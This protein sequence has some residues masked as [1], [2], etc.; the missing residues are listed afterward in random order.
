M[1]LL[2]GLSTYSKSMASVCVALSVV[3]GAEAYMIG[4][5]PAAQGLSTATDD[6][7]M[8]GASSATP[9]LQFPAFITYR[10]VNERPL[11]SDTRRPPP[12][13]ATSGISRQAVQLASKWKVT[14]IV[15]AG[16]NS[17]AHVEG[18]RDRKTVRLQLGMPLDGWQ[19][20]EVHPDRLVFGSADSAVTLRLH[21]KESPQKDGSPAGPPRRK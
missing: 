14:G 5:Q 12:K 1:G 13:A 2:S 17:F 3:I 18:I 7:A 8:L 4:A 19:L 21:E 10:A 15:V 6:T 9:G 16:D 20:E 11:F